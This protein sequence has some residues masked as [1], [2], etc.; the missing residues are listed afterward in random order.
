MIG[1]VGCS[2]LYDG[3]GAGGAAW[4]LKSHYMDQ[5]LDGSNSGVLEIQSRLAK[6]Y[7]DYTVADACSVP[8]ADSV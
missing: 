1:A 8:G 3:H 5:L 2:G 4:G 7:P 6:L